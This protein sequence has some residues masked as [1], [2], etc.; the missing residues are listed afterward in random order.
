MTQVQSFHTGKPH[1]KECLI[2]QAAHCRHRKYVSKAQCVGLIYHLPF[3]YNIL[4]STEVQDSLPSL[5]WNSCQ[6]CSEMKYYKR[7]LEGSG[8]REEIVLG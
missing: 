2:V 5:K 1:Q 3:V 7:L 6:L 4:C 8:N